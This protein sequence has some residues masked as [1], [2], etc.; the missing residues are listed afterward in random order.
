[1]YFLYLPSPYHDLYISTRRQSYRGVYSFFMIENFATSRPN[2][3]HLLSEK[4]L[5]SPLCAVA[6]YKQRFWDDYLGGGEC[7]NGIF[8]ERVR[9]VRQKIVDGGPARVTDSCTMKPSI[10]SRGVWLDIHG[11]IEEGDYNLYSVWMKVT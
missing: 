5:L 3:F 4:T 7:V 10:V 6:L 11:W 9:K 1:M 8:V 2:K